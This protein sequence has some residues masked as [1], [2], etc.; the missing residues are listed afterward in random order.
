MKNTPKFDI[1]LS[2]TRRPLKGNK[3]HIENSVLLEKLLNKKINIHLKINLD[4]LE[5]EYNKKKYYHKKVKQ[6]K[7]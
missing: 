7:N 3:K 2:F 1:K 4:K 6:I 5:Q